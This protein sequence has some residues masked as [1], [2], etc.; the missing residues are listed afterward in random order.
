M[1]KNLINNLIPFLVKKGKKSTVEKLIRK[2][3]VFHSVSNEKNFKSSFNQAVTN[4]QPFIMLKTKRIR[5]KNSL[6]PT[7]ITKNHSNFLKYSWLAKGIA[8]QP[9]SIFS[10]RFI[11]A[12][13]L[14]SDK[15]GWAIEKQKEM[16]KM[17]FENI[18][19]RRK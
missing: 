5:G 17:A 3:L 4:V 1:E 15:K 12:I 10:K 19:M 11:N 6:V 2:G 7:I 13:K 9:E 16:H 8:K 14:N 18:W